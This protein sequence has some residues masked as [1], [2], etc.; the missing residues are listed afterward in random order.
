MYPSGAL[1]SAAFVIGFAAL[2]GHQ[3]SIAYDVGDPW[4][5][6]PDGVRYRFEGIYEH[7][8]R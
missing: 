2:L 4:F 1:R 3:T 7:Y 8:E 6:G 5:P